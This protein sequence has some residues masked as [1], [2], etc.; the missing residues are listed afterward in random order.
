MDFLPQMFNIF[1]LGEGQNLNFTSGRFIWPWSVRWLE[2]Q[3]RRE[4]EPISMVWTETLRGSVRVM[5]LE[6]E[7]KQ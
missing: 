7:R 2:E 6:L 1:R 3:G 4:V 5:A